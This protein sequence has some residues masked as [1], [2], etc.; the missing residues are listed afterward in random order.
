MQFPSKVHP[1]WFP[2]LE[3][4]FK[5]KK[6]EYLRTEVLPKAPY[7]PSKEL[8]FCVFEMPVEK[9]NVVILGQDPYPKKKDAVGLAFA[10]SLD[11]NKPASLRI[12]EKELGKE[13]PND[14]STWVEQGVL[15]LNT[16]LTV[17]IGTPDSH[18]EY[19][20]PFMQLLIANL[21]NVK[22]EIV[23]LLWGK[24]AQSFEQY[25]HPHSCTLTA[26][27]PA[28]EIYKPGSGSFLGCN[29]FHKTNIILKPQIINW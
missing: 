21:S 20:K 4:G 19:W 11:N 16:A 28:T 10:T 23:W 5:D 2:I 18:S 6:L 29:H 3:E 14:L 8:I 25:I 17:E 7:S 15:L 26:G 12:I 13:V 9:V 22:P 24:K 1:S 27:H